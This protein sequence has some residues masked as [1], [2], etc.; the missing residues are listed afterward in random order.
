MAASSKLL[1]TS[2]PLHAWTRLSTVLL[3][4]MNCAASAVCSA[5]LQEPQPP[6]ESPDGKSSPAAPLVG[7]GKQEESSIPARELHTLNGHTDWVS[8]VAF[9]PDGERLAS[10]SW[11]KTARIWDVDTGEP[12][13]VLPPMKSE[14]NSVAFSPAGNKLALVGFD[15]TVTIV[16]GETGKLLTT[17]EGRIGPPVTFS[18]DGKQLTAISA[19]R[20]KME[21]VVA[22]W[23]TTSGKRIKVLPGY[24]GAGEHCERVVLSPNQL[25]H[26][27]T[28]NNSQGEGIKMKIMETLH[29]GSVHENLTLEGAWLPL[30]FSPNGNWLALATKDNVVKLLSMTGDPSMRS[31]ATS[32]SNITD[33]TFSPNGQWLATTSQDTTARIWDVDSGVQ[34][35]SLKGHKHSISCVVFSHDGTRLATSSFDNTVKIWTLTSD[36]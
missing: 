16:D 23:D 24:S 31:I 29:E 17:L 5:T 35:F 15:H 12:L 13:L 19:S 1:T 6:A 27:V 22:V 9:S 11:D 25:Y 21:A 36:P 14:L 30:N 8:A 32:V 33:V 18:R 28:I 2:R 34:R 3:L 7:A 10:V 4:L 26:A 20:E